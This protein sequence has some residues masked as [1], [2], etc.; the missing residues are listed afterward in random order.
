MSHLI[1]V[2][3]KSLDPCITVMFSMIDRALKTLINVNNSRLLFQQLGSKRASR[4]WVCKG[5]DSVGVVI[6]FYATQA[7]PCPRAL[8]CAYACY[9]AGRNGDDG[10]KKA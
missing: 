9:S 5:R 2:G 7:G 1:V 3:P 10:G 8:M 6:S 4:A